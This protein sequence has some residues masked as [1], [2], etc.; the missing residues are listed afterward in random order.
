MKVDLWL[1][2]ALLNLRSGLKGFWIFLACLSLGVAAIAIIGSLAASIDRGLAE[3]GQPLLGGDLEFSLIQRDVDDK[4]RAYISKLGDVSKTIVLRAMAQSHGATALVELKAVDDAY[5]LYGKLLMEPAQP[6]KAGTVAVDPLLLGRLNLNIGDKLKIGE[7]EFTIASAITTEPDRI[8]DGFV[9]GPRVLITGQ[10]LAATRLIQPGSLVTWKYRVRLKGD[11]S[12][13]ATKALV[14][15]A[16]KAFPQSGWRVKARDEA[17]NGAARFIERLQ[18]FLTLVGVASLVTGGAGI[19]NAVRA[20]IARRRS[21]IAT[22]KCL[23]VNGNDIA[24]MFLTE[25]II[26][27]LIG[28]GAGLAAGAIAPWVMQRLFGSVLPLPV[29]TEITWGPLAFAGLLGFLTT[30]AFSLW[31]LARI[32]SISGTA[33]FRSHLVETRSSLSWPHIVGSLACLALAAT[34]ILLWFDNLRITAIYLAGLAASFVALAALSYLILKLIA[35]LP[36]P[37][38]ILARHAVTSLYRP[39]ASSLP[40]IMSLG[41]GLSLFVTLALT[42]ATIS[43]ELRS[44][45][46]DKAP[47]FFFLDVPNTVLPEFESAL[48]SQPGAG[49][50]GNAPMLRGRIVKVNGIDADKLKPDPEASW[51]LRGDRGLTYSETLPDGSELVEGTWWAKDYEGPPLVSLVDDIARG[52]HLKIGDTITVNALGR[53]IEARVENFRRVNWRSMG[54]NFVMVFSPMPLKLAPHSHIV[55][56]DMKTG[57]EAKLLNTIAASYPSI[58]AIRVKDAL[59]LVSDL[60]GKMLTAVRGA[61]ALTLLTGILVLAGA[62]A[63]SLSARSYESVVL[64]TYGATRSQLLTSFIIE[65]GA[66]GLVAA[67]FGILTGTLGAW[68]IARFILELPWA[69][70]LPLAVATALLSVTLAIVTGLLTTAR[71]LSA[72]PS[73]YLRNE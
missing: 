7:A 23:G 42:D 12:L 31:P 1:R 63:A 3:Q 22:L 2:Y 18:Y 69:F 44:G 36:K 52:L 24:G 43:R 61:N 20:F 73:T 71:A 29:S 14:E 60:M 65:Y 37:S 57:D 26:V 9:L 66:L 49:E 51:A 59:T 30:L 72:K 55:T 5:P 41:L 68:Y 48:K 40:V 62:V 21:T 45:I 33:L 56:L 46:P 39:G 27:A 16:N 67:A 11:T 70:S 54:I 35:R 32:S 38:H 34:A 58:T 19:A 13:K 50:I 64:K 8:S 6:L 10:G 4:E 17:A 47:A 25:I 28:I 53:D 15:D